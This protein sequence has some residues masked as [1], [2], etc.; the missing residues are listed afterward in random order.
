LMCVIPV[1]Y[2]TVQLPKDMMEKVRGIITEYP[3][4]GYGSVKSFVEDSVRRRVEQVMK[5]CERKRVL[6]EK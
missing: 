6:R 5:L 4:L 1:T 3:E 2:K